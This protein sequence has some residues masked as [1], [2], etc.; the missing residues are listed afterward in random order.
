MRPSALHFGQFG[1]NS[2]RTSDPR[3][4][5]GVKRREWP[6]QNKTVLLQATTHLRAP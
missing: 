2:L 5:A 4:K 1:G 6:R 3:L